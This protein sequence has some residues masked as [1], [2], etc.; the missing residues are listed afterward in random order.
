VLSDNGENQ[1]VGLALVAVGFLI[2]VMVLT[3]VPHL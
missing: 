3:L 2:L 1:L